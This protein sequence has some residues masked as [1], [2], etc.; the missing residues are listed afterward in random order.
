MFAVKVN[1]GSEFTTQFP[2]SLILRITLILIK[3][4][5]PQTNPLEISIDQVEL[6]IKI[7]YVIRC[8]K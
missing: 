8:S 1:I 4:A 5:D 2:Q 3:N 7:T 6:G